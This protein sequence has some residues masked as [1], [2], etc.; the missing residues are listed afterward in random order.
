M[1][2]QWIRI[3][4]TDSRLGLFESSSGHGSRL[5][6]RSRSGPSPRCSG[7]KI[8]KCT[9]LHISTYFFSDLHEGRINNRKS[10]TPAKNLLT[11]K[12]FFSIV[13]GPLWPT[14]I[15]NL[16]QISKLIFHWDELT[17]FECVVN[18]RISQ[19]IFLYF[20]SKSTDVRGLFHLL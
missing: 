3:R 6:A 15:R 7:A 2:I 17:A 14:W 18:C 11:L 10:F 16:T 4:N 9:T 19:P 5:L 1:W 12:Y 13:W 20:V 8:M